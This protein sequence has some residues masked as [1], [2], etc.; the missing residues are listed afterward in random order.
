MSVKKWQMSVM[1]FF[2]YFSSSVISPTR[3]RQNKSRMHIF[4]VFSQKRVIQLEGKYQLISIL[5][6]FLMQKMSQF[7]SLM[8]YFY[9]EKKLMTE[10]VIWCH[11]SHGECTQSASKFLFY[12]YFLLCFFQDYVNIFLA[13]FLGFGYF[14]LSAFAHIQTHTH[15]VIHCLVPMPC[16]CI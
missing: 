11:P 14:F 3:S 1:I 4:L 6:S 9:L 12:S 2:S 10:H 5:L 8:G 16:S 7:W 15:R 13:T